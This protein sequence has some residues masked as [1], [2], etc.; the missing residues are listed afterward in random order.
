MLEF[1]FCCSFYVHNL[2]IAFAL[3]SFYKSFLFRLF[4]SIIGLP[5]LSSTVLS[6]STA[7]GRFPLSRNDYCNALSDCQY[8][9]MSGRELHQRVINEGSII[10]HVVGAVL[11]TPPVSSGTAVI[12]RGPCPQHLCFVSLQF[13]HLAPI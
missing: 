9:C 12:Y 5:M 1:I 10:L 2:F 3:F 8:Y 6:I 13:S 11:Q 4:S 7:K